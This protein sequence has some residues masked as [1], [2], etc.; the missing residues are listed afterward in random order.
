MSLLLQAAIVLPL[1]AGATAV[2]WWRGWWRG[3][4]LAAG[5]S[6]RVELGL[7]D[8]AGAM[9]AM[10]LGMLV[11]QRV[12]VSLGLAVDAAATQS[13]TPMDVVLSGLVIQTLV[14]GLAAGYVLT[15]CGLQPAGLRELGLTRGP[16][17]RVVRVS[18][19]G[20]VIA[21]PMVLALAGA[22]GLVMALLG[23]PPPP[24]G[25][26][27]L[28]VL[29]D[30][31]RPGEYAALV[32]SA[33]VLAP[34]LEEILFRGLLQTAIGNLLGTSWRWVTI[35][36]CSLLFAL[37]HGSAGVPPHGIAALVLLAVILGWTYERTGSLWPAILIHAGFNAFNVAMVLAMT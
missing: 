23:D 5:P 21:L 19:V 28:R 10:L 8:V 34:V 26:N 35:G 29:Q 18:A 27:L 37:T 12:V 2:V 20:L 30:M 1:G 11:A 31:H 15:R 25:H 4:M 36:I 7:M 3:Q 16:I 22:L 33:V 13:A 24:V 14:H 17:D 32:L 6:R 9:A